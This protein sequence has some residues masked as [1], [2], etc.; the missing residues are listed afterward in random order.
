MVSSNGKS[1][2]TFNPEAEPTLLVVVD[3]HFLNTNATS[4][5]G[6]STSESWWFVDEATASF[7]RA[8][9]EGLMNI[10]LNVFVVGSRPNSNES[11]TAEER[12]E[13]TFFMEKYN[14]MD[15]A[16]VE[17]EVCHIPDSAADLRKEVEECNFDQRLRHRKNLQGVRLLGTTVDYYPYS[18]PKTYPELVDGDAGNVSLWTGIYPEV[19]VIMCKDLNFSIDLVKE[20]KWGSLYAGGMWTGMLGILYSVPYSKMG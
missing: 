7:G 14:I 10:D 4:D 2:H 6:L 20:K 12:E 1:E 3:P 5:A 18:T 19:A 15:H 8:R 17:R 16:R 9:L 13:E 11:A